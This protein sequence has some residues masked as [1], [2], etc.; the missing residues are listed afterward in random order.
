MGNMAWLSHNVHHVL[1]IVCLYKHVRRCTIDHRSLINCRV[2]KCRVIKCRQTV[3]SDL[4]DLF[5]G[6]ERKK[7]VNHKKKT[8]KKQ[9]EGKR[10][11]S[12]VKKGIDVPA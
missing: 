9:K 11:L 6:F 4:P 10:S 12:C 1:V 3:Y 8:E 2:I 5:A 7:M